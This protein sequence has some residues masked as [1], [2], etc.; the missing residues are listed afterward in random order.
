MEFFLKVFRM[1]AIARCYIKDIK[2]IYLS[3]GYINVKIG[4]LNTENIC[5]KERT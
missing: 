4:D 1:K 2:H 3:D 5:T